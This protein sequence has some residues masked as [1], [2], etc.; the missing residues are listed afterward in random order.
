VPAFPIRLSRER[1]VNLS[2]VYFG[3]DQ[4][5]IT[6]AMIPVL[7]ANARWLRAHPE[8]RVRVEG[9]TDAQGTPEYNLSLGVRRATAVR[10]YLVQSGVPAESLELV[11][12]GEELPLISGNQ[13]GAFRKN[14]RAEFSLVEMPKVSQNT[15]PAKK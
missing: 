14:R 12:F 15:L 4:W 13:E 6:P 11:S 3:F 10:D 2:R 5:A 8:V 9:H 7:D 1:V